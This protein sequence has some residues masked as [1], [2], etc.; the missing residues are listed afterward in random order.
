MISDLENEMVNSFQNIIY[1][2]EIGFKNGLCGEPMPKFFLSF[3][4]QKY[5]DHNFKIA[6]NTS[7]IQKVHVRL[8]SGQFVQLLAIKLDEFQIKKLGKKTSLNSSKW[9]NLKLGKYNR[10]RYNLAIT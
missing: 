9:S 2:V 1:V 8:S 3:S 6:N 4:T 10:F 5:F 7:G